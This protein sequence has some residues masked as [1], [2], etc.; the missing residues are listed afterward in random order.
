[1]S[2]DF[3]DHRFRS[4]RFE[5]GIVWPAGLTRHTA[6][7]IPFMYSFAGNCA[8]RSLSAGFYIPVSVSDLYIPMIGPSIFL[9][10]N[11]LIDRG[12]I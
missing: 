8:M 9:Q 6:R 11:R 2:D 1:M 4:P 5:S 10:K 3:L 7:K 12:N